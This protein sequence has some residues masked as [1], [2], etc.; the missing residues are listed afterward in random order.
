MNRPTLICLAW[1]AL[2][3]AASAQTS[4]PLFSVSG[5]S[6]PN[7]YNTGNY[8][9]WSQA[10]FSIADLSDGSASTY[11]T[12]HGLDNTLLANNSRDDTGTFYLLR[13]NLPPSQLAFHIDF[14]AAVQYPG[15]AETLLVEA[16][17]S[18]GINTRD[19]FWQY[20]A[21]QPSTFGVTL[22][23]TGNDGNQGAYGQ[24]YG[25]D[26]MQRPDGSI[27]IVLQGSY[28]GQSDRP[29]LVSSTLYDVSAT[30]APE[31]ASLALLLLG[32]FSLTL[33]K[34]RQS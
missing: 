32:G 15:G 11:V 5:G 24:D 30:S 28:F 2:S 31:P 22:Y 33:R 7:P 8:F 16:V 10:P 4:F 34:K 29:G 19:V 17:S 6:I 13:Y 20:N 18:D 1:I 23:R 25:L 14:T 21:S 12:L 9:T 26:D 3:A 27:Y